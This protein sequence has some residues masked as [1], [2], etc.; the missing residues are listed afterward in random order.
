MGV[1]GW[2]GGGGGGDFAW[3]TA[4]R[5]QCGGLWGGLSNG[6]VTAFPMHRYST[7]RYIYIY[8]YIYIYT[9]LLK[10]SNKIHLG[11][12]CCFIYFFKSQ[13]RRCSNDTIVN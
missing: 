9:Y 11:P 4:Q 5:L 8:I 13:G 3:L 12:G 6:S 10:L 2:G 7:D 1:G